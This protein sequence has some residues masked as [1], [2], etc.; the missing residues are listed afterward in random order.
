MSKREKLVC[1]KRLLEVMI[2]FLHRAG[3]EVSFELASPDRIIAGMSGRGT[4]FT[5]C[6]GCISQGDSVPD[7]WESAC[8]GCA[9]LSS[10]TQEEQTLIEGIGCELGVYD[11]ERQLAVIQRLRTRLEDCLHTADREI[12]EKSSSYLT[13]PLL[14]SCLAALLII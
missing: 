11:A 12:R 6:A 13:C 1:R 5:L 10:L 8:K 7:A 14:V 3:G 4:F 2:E 9:E